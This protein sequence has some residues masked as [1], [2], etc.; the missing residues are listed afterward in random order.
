MLAAPPTLSVSDQWRHGMSF[1]CFDGRLQF[2]TEEEA[3]NAFGGR[4]RLSIDLDPQVLRMDAASRNDFVDLL[5]TA[6]SLWVRACVICRL[7]NLV[8]VELDGRT[9]AHPGLYGP[10]GKIVGRYP[11]PPKT[12][13]QPDADA[14]ES[15]LRSGLSAGRIGA[16]IQSLPYVEVRKPLKDEFAPLCAAAAEGSRHP[17]LG[18]VQRTLCSA[19]TPDR[20]AKILVR[21][22]DGNTYCGND[23][24]IIACRADTELTEFNVRD[25][26]FLVGGANLRSIGSGNTEVDFLH[27]VLHEMGHW[28]G[29]DDLKR[30]ESIMAASM[31]ESRCINV[32]TVKVLANTVVGRSIPPKPAAFTYR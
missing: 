17:T 20:S 32:E 13:P 5:L 24:N 4:P 25:Y 10:F 1:L 12:Q 15:W 27:T 19:A 23:R 21:L 2:V 9:F 11:E 6:A 8:I 26:K 28:I 16:P 31:L 14:V 22:R 30:G 3:S 29:M 7:D 18:R